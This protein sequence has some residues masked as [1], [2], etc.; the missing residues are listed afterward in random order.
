MKPVDATSSLDRKGFLRY[1]AGLLNRCPYWAASLSPEQ[2]DL[3]ARS[4][5]GVRYLIR[6]EAQAPARA[7]DLQALWA[8]QQAHRA[9]GALLI[10]VAGQHSPLIREEARA[11]RLHLWTLE[12]VDYLI[13]AADL[14]SN[15]PLAYLGLEVGVS[16]TTPNPK[17]A[18][19]QQA[20]QRF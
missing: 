8:A 7:E 1:V 15:A 9:D 13:M 6:V 16:T 19:V 11:R 12:E 3:I 5:S 2:D 17:T 10:A 4:P 18:L 20:A 14:E